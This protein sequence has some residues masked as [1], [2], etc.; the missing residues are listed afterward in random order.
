[1][2]RIGAPAWRKP[3]FRGN[4]NAAEAC[5]QG[6]GMGTN[7]FGQPLRRKED[8]RLL[9]GRGQFTADMIRP[10]MPHAVMLRSPHAQAPLVAIDT[11]AGR[12]APGVLAV[13]AARR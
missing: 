2:G 12:A 1:M 5:H 10:G 4:V 8:T 13:V 3:A 11:E 6:S 7:A 9:T